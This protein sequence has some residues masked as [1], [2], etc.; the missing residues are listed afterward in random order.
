[1]LD[2]PDVSPWEP[3]ELALAADE[4]RLD[5]I[6]EAFARVIEAKSPFTASHSLRVAEI[7]VG[8]ATVL[9]FDAQQLR[10]LS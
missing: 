3:R 2:A 4:T 10:T 1:M 8:I 5:R 6:A 9:G 7:T